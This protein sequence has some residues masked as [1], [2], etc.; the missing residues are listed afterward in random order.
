MF[1]SVNV[2]C[3]IV[4]L[5]S[6]CFPLC[7]LERANKMPKQATKLSAIEML[8]QKYEKKAALNERELEFQKYESDLKQRKM[9]ME[10]EKKQQVQIE[11]EEKRA[12]LELF[13]MELV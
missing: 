12:F 10:E 4:K 5:V 7:I 9:D 1:V 2:S 13:H 6:H 8:Q 11:L 3:K